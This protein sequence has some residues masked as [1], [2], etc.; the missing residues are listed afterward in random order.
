MSWPLILGA[1][2]SVV[3]ALAALCL[4]RQIEK[5]DRLASRIAAAR[6]H[7]GL[8]P[9]QDGPSPNRL[10]AMV[11]AAGTSLTRSGI[12][13]SKT[14]TELQQTLAVSG[15]RRHNAL[16]IFVGSKLLLLVALPSMS[17]F[18]LGALGVSPLVHSAATA[19]FAIV[20][21]IGPDMIIK[22]IRARYVARLGKGLPDALDMMIICSEAGLG[23]EPS[24]SRVAVEITQTHP[25][26]SN[27]LFQTASELRVISDRR[28]ALQNLGART[29]LEGL[30]RLSSTL[31]QTYQYGTP[32]S[33]ALRTLSAE[34]RGDML[35]KFEERAARLPVLLTIPMIVFI[36]PTV[37]I[38]VGGPA[39]MKVMASFQ[40][41]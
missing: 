29:D 32:V 13:S 38:V 31:I 7:A 12:L 39:I 30:K 8:T 18:G 9:A 6:R 1:V 5:Q 41:H 3:V 24:I 23:L 27:E 14:L 37:F 19:T 20:G 34:M 10:V 16:G 22:K 25:A 11:S 26:V 21:L 36:L 40:H 35:T 17:W 28:L 33:Q 2:G 4:M 15:L